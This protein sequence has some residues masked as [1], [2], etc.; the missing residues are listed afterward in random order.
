MS[1]KR[2]KLS[3]PV[4]DK[5]AAARGRFVHFCM[6]AIRREMPRLLEHLFLKVDDALYDLADKSETNSLYITYF[7]AMRAIRRRRGDIEELFLGKLAEPD[8][9]RTR[10]AP[11]SRAE[12]ATGRSTQVPASTDSEELEETLAITNLIS[13]AQS[14]YQHE[15][16]ELRRRF[17]ALPA[18]GAGGARA[19]P[20]E[21]RAICNAFRA[22]LQPVAEVELSIKLVI[23]KLFDKQVMDHLGGIY[24]R[25]LENA[26]APPIAIVS[27][28]GFIPSQNPG[29]ATEDV[30]YGARGKAQLRSLDFEREERGGNPAPRTHR[31]EADAIGTADFNFLRKLLG[32]RRSR[33]PSVEEGGVVDTNEL[34]STLSGMQARTGLYGS[35][36]MSV[37]ALRQRMGEELRL[38]GRGK[39]GRGLHPVDADTLDLVFLLFEHILQGNDIPDTVKVLIG[40]LQIPTAKVALVDK[41]FFEDKQHPSRRLLNHLAEIAVGWSDEGDRTPEGVYGRIEG[42][43]DRILTDY[44]R[45]PG[46]FEELD[47]ELTAGLARE[48]GKARTWESKAQREIEGRE[49]DL[50]AR[51]MVREVITERLRNRS[52]V[53]E[54]VSLLLYEGWQEVMLSAYLAGG[55]AGDDWRSALATID[56]LL[57]SIRPKVEYEDRRALLR[58]IPGLLRTLRESLV[59]VSYDQRRLARLFKDLQALHLAAL[60][61]DGP[62]PVDGG[63]L[64]DV[65]SA[66]PILQ[67]V[68]SSANAASER[69]TSTGA[70]TGLTEGT[71]IELRR[72]D[73]SRLRV[74]LAWRSETSDKHLFVSREGQ[75]VLELAGTDLAT[76]FQQGLVKVLSKGDMSVVDRAMEAVLQT[77]KAS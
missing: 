68:S 3:L 69:D 34:I 10:G 36:A 56:R 15:L 57:W 50:S 26:T 33:D 72:D 32:Q 53:P 12:P 24:S 25:C 67:S 4:P 61:G 29:K 47:S 37:D 65:S 17:A 58:N 46:I 38:H 14:R 16:L 59:A 35:Y 23:Y 60:R 51:R 18:P 74:K 66:S 27:V 31:P 39:S 54:V 21:P 22:A 30:G 6:D 11:G 40:R 64:G 43:V 5:T 13:K 55:T 49:R 73:G 1:G 8:D 77:L 28:P 71:W 76:L 44:D 45:D 20:L 63:S 7:D 9:A 62:V 48:H 41:S 75:K 2:D 19:G 42:V 70:V 52:P